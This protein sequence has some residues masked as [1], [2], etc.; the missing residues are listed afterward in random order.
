MLCFRSD[1]SKPARLRHKKIEMRS[2]VL[3]KIPGPHK[4]SENSQM[5]EAADHITAL[6]RKIDF[7]ADQLERL[8]NVLQSNGVIEDEWIN[9]LSIQDQS[10]G[11]GLAIE[12]T[13]LIPEAQQPRDGLITLRSVLPQP[14]KAKG[15]TLWSLV[16]QYISELLEEIKKPEAKN[17]EI[18][19][20]P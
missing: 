14:T 10:A 13:H 19:K 15:G 18:L 5:L 1:L 8:Q 2:M 3:A 6:E 17:S 11:A 16:D 9:E 7:L 4:V 20:V 12:G